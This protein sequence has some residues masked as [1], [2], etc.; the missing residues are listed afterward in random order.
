M[1]EWVLPV[2]QIASALVGGLVLWA[3]KAG[4]YVQGQDFDHQTL[5]VV[6]QQISD[7][8]RQVEQEDIAR[9]AAVDATNAAIGKLTMDVA[10][11]RAEQ[12]MRV[13]HLE[14]TYSAALDRMEAVEQYTR[15]LQRQID[16]GYRR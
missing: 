9:R 2:I 6:Q 11:M 10:V 1:P 15:D 12:K 4:R 5:R 14:A 13:D 7:L 3:I 16:K 8:E